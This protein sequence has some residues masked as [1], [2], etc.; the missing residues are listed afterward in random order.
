MSLEGHLHDQKSLRAV[1]GKTAD[2]NELAK[3]CV[4]FAN[5]AGGTLSIGIEDGQEVP[6]P[7][8]KIPADLP[9]LLRRK[10]GERTVNVTALPNVTTAVNG[11][12]Y[13]ELSVPRSTGVASTTDGRYYLRVADQSKPV[14]G[15]DVMRLASERAALPW[16]T[17]TSLSVPRSD[18]D[19]S[20]LQTVLSA[21]RTSDR[22]K[23]SVKEKS[24]DELLD[25]YQMAR[26]PY[27][28]NL[29]ILCVGQ[30]FR[31]AQ[32]TTAPVI[33]FLKYDEEG[34]KVNKLV[35]DDHT[36]NPI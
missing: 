2:W 15:D 22:V 36:L 35:W 7:N 4:A 20:K 26:G 18:A 13:I 34:Q 1:T 14:T 30:Q 27:L 23:P 21:L 25:H 19:P 3:D 5:A 33:Q 17:Q 10:L 6:E 32:L 16:E 29:G 11:G 24:A 31:R 8:Q 28:T 12:Q 9:D